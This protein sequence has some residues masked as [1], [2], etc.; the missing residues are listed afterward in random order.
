MPCRYADYRA[1]D[2]FTTWHTISTVGSFALGISFLPFGYNVWKSYRFGRTVHVDDP[3]TIDRTVSGSTGSG[4]SNGISGPMPRTPRS[5]VDQIRCT[6]ILGDGLL[7]G[8]LRA[9]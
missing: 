5:V 1:S 4:T 8:S 9:R 3:L 7:L 2:G 6:C